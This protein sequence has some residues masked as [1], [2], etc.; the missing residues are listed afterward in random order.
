MDLRV[1][2]GAVLAIFLV[3]PHA[4][5]DEFKD[6]VVLF[7]GNRIDGT[8]KSLHHGVLMIETAYSEND[9]E[10]EWDDVKSIRSPDSFLFHL[11]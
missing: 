7:N 4:A 9:F 1:F 8:I 5:S 11:M 2:I 3:L 10:I 6:T